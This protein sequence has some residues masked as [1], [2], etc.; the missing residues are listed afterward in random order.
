MRMRFPTEWMTNP[1]YLDFEGYSLPVP[2][3]THR[4]LEISF[5]DYMQLPDEADRVA[6]HNAVFIDLENSYTK[7]KGVHYCVKK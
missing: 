5:G 4:Y 1:K 7:Y 2:S 3:D 6:R